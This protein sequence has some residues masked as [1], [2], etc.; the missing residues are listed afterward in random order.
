MNN[1]L[2]LMY[3]IEKYES[4]IIELEKWDFKKELSSFTKE[5]IEDSNI[6]DE[7]GKRMFINGIKGV[8]S[9]LK[10]GKSLEDGKLYLSEIIA[11]E[12]P[13]F[14]PNNLILSPT[15]SG[16]TV[17][18]K[19]LAKEAKNRESLLLVST[20]SLKLKFVPSDEK[21]REILSNRMYSTK[22]KRIYGE[23]HEK[24]L[25]MTYAEFGEKMKY[26]YDYAEKFSM[27]FCDEVHS[28]I[29]YQTYE[30]SVNLFLLMRYLFEEHENQTIYHFTATS[31]HIDKLKDLSDRIMRD[32]KVFNYLDNQEIKRYIS[33]SSY[34]I[35]GIEQI[36]SHLIARKE[37]FKYFGYK[38]FAFCKTIE[39]QKRMKKICEEEGYTAQAYWS[40]N[41]EEKIMTEEQTEEME[42]M[43]K[44]GRLPDKYDVVIINAA[45]QEGW[46]LKDE[47]VKLAIIN[48]KN[49]TEHIQALGRIRNDLDVLVYKVSQDEEMDFYIDFPP[50]Y[51]GKPLDTKDKKEL[52]KTFNL[53]DKQG[54]LLGWNSVAKILENQGFLIT[55]K[56]CKINNQRRIF[57]T[58]TPR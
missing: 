21:E 38:I 55:S 50:K 53:R 36:R 9:R 48:T 49:E 15:G 1:K 11:K 25:V 44:E 39:S 24:I 32:V 29:A 42:K 16:K 40:V 51:L 28:L 3:E 58:I 54:R 37:S 46:D 7:S 8:I 35:H 10:T 33:L 26:S 12:K 31:E 43:V 52:S 47:R 13:D 17:F 14:G 45:L 19:K 20:T 41:N 34:K 57:T 27:I 22:Q 5:L 30:S 56:R 18:I 23:G 2:N 4:S 6:Q